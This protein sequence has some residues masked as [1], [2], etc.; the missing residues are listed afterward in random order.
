MRGALQMSNRWLGS[1]G[2]LVLLVAGPAVAADMPLKAPPM[3][4]AIV[5]WTGAYIGVNG[6][7][8]REDTTWTFTTPQ[9]FDDVG[10]HSFAVNPST[11]VLGGHVGYNMESNSFVFG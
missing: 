6:G 4:P 3:A 1:A 7:W 9:F 11:G 2:A 8:G 10:G 5:D